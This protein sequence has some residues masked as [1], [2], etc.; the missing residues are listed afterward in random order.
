M[1]IC[2]YGCGR[3]AKYQFKNGKWC[4]SKNHKQCSGLSY[5]PPLSISKIPCPE[6]KKLIAKNRIKHHIESCIKYN[7]CLECKNKTKNPKFCS[8]KCSALYNNKHSKELRAFQDKKIQDGIKNRGIRKDQLKKLN[9]KI[10]SIIKVNKCLYCLKPVNNKFCNNSCRASYKRNIKIKKWLNGEL[11]GC[12]QGGHASYVK[13]YLLEKY[14][15]KC[16]KCG[17]S[18]INPYTKNIPLEVEHIDGN[19]YN[20]KPNNVTLLCPNCHSLTATFRGANKGNG[21]RTYLKKYYIKNDKGKT[22]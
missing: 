4:C 16:S 1:K 21:R 2:E 18:E 3:K 12:S 10:I 7:I 5:T 22:I 17:W 20:N 13:Y 11:D 6:C 9:N 19:P 15:H 8:K 14:N